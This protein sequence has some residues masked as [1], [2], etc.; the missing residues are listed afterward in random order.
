MGTPC[1]SAITSATTS[2]LPL[3]WIM[4][5]G[6]PVFLSFIL[7]KQWRT[8]WLS[9]LHI[10]PG[11]NSLTSSRA[12]KWPKVS[13]VISLL[14]KRQPRILAD[15]LR[16]VD[17]TFLGDVMSSHSL[18]MLGARWGSG[19]PLLCLADILPQ[20]SQSLLTAVVAHRLLLVLCCC[21]VKSIELAAPLLFLQ[22]PF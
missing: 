16:V 19:Q 10:L 22:G 8:L 5:W 9:P 18:R 7:T 21:I 11:I 17:G 14:L 3:L 4:S 1:I 12:R 6:L 15:S 20:P 13:V 2:V